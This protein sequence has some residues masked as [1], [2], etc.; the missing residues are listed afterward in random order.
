MLETIYESQA[1]LK[2][3]SSRDVVEVVWVIL[4]YWPKLDALEVFCYCMGQQIKVL[5]EYRTTG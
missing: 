1:Q 3:K 5:Y 4:S 2:G